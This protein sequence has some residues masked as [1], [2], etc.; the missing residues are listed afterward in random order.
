[1]QGRSKT[2][3]LPI[4]RQIARRSLSPPGSIM[5]LR[6]ILSDERLLCRQR[7]QEKMHGMA[8]DKES[9]HSHQESKEHKSEYSFVRRKSDKW[10]VRF[11]AVAIY[12]VRCILFRMRLLLFADGRS[13]HSRL[14]R[15]VCRVNKCLRRR[16][17]NWPTTAMMTWRCCLRRPRWCEGRGSRQETTPG[18]RGWRKRV[19]WD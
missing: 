9:L 2:P 14:F 5:V 18:R 8:P 15:R 6:P 3:Q 12:L 16:K 17:D 1:M 7:E 19:K 11:S 10:S 13:C 4:S